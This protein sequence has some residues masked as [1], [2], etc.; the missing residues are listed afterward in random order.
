MNTS[1]TPTTPH[2]ENNVNKVSLNGKQTDEWLEA[3][4]EDLES[5]QMD[6]LWFA[7]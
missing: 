2:S 3:C 1:S 7:E 6:E 4:S 5:N